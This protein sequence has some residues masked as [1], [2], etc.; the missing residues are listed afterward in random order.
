[1]GIVARR[2]FLPFRQL[3][4][5][6]KLVVIAAITAGPATAAL[7]V[8]EW[9][10]PNSILPWAL[11]ATPIALALSASGLMLVRGSR[12][13][14]LWLAGILALSG[15]GVVLAFDLEIADHPMWAAGLGVAIAYA[16]ACWALLPW[17]RLRPYVGLRKKDGL[18]EHDVVTVTHL[19]TTDRPFE[20]SDA[21]ARPPAVGDVGTV[22]GVND[23]DPPTWCVVECVDDDGYTLWLAQFAPGELKRLWR[24][25][26]AEDPTL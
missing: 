19:A 10:Y 2:V 24:A 26:L 17:S 15:V 9:L 1:M 23:E 3:P 6:L 22:V 21:V 16:L 11:M 7:A 13:G 4:W 25:P 14:L 12:E 8:L 20:G 18:G 5:H